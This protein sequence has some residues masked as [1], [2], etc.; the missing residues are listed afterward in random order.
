MQID[1]LGS[2]VHNFTNP[3]GD[4]FTLRCFREAPGCETKG[5]PIDDFTWFPG[6]KWCFS[7]CVN[8]GVQ[9]GWFYLSAEDSFFGIIREAL[10]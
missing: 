1:M 6:Y 8:C 3:S 2:H 10:A 5:V 7:F 9:S 4:S